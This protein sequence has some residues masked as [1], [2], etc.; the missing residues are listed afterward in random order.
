[1]LALHYGSTF[2]PLKFVL[3]NF[4]LTDNNCTNKAL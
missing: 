2:N 4:D 1:M 3:L